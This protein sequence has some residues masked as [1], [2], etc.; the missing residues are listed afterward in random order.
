MLHFTCIR[1]GPVESSETWPQDQLRGEGDY[2]FVRARCTIVHRQ[3]L[4]RRR[5]RNRKSS[6]IAWTY[7]TCVE[8]RTP[9]PERPG[10]DRGFHRTLPRRN[11]CQAWSSLAS[12]TLANTLDK[13]RVSI[14]CSY[15]RQ[16]QFGRRI[17]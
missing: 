7:H 15:S 17:D 14:S 2:G 8:S 6:S 10:R 16:G 11:G 3:G 13:P 1:K 5:L 12:K 9:L 4:G